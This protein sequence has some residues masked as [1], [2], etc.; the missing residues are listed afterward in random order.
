MCYQGLCVFFFLMIRRPP[1]S[2]QSRSSAASDVYKRSPCRRSAAVASASRQGRWVRSESCPDA[3]CRDLR[4]GGSGPAVFPMRQPSYPVVYRI[5][6]T[7]MAPNLGFRALITR[8]QLDAV[9]FLAPPAPSKSRLLA[10]RSAYVPQ[11]DSKPCLLCSAQNA[12]G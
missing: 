4:N 2:T 11:A 10:P 9:C 7:D 5:G 8:T 12:N 1:R 3:W 6:T